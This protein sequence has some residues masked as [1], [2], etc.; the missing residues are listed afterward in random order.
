M[1]YTY[2]NSGINI[3]RGPGLVNWDAG[4]FKNFQIG[5]KLRLQFRSEF[6]NMLITPHFGVPATNIQAATAGKILTTVGN[7][8]QIQF[9]LTLMF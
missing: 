1:L 8:R 2:G 7:P 9:A 6:F 5:E 3:L 4:L